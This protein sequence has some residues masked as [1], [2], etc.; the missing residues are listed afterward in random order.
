MIL[1]PY[2][3]KGYGKLLIEFSTYHS[4]SLKLSKKVAD[5]I[6]AM[7]SQSMK[8]RLGLQRSHYRIWDT[9]DTGRIGLQSSLEL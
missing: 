6:Q 8:I 1:P 9:V 5:I 3:R 2:Q 4:I 7:S